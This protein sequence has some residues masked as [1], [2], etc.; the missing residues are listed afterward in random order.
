MVQSG[1][2][3]PKKPGERYPGGQLKPGSGEPIAP[4]VLRRIFRDAEDGYADAR[5]GSQVGRLY[6]HRQ[7]TSTEA[8]TAFYIGEIYGRYEAQIG[9]R[10]S[11][12]SPSYESGLAA[13]P[14]RNGLTT[15]SA[16]ALPR[17]RNN[18]WRCRTNSK[19]TAARRGR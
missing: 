9:K 16:T 12:R 3:R 17:S 19:P 10:R 15:S 11:T 5:L 7:L 2:G 8:S 6:F 4:T 18:G 13:T 14:A 1:P